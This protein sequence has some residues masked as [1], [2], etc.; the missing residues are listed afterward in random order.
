MEQGHRRRLSRRF[1]LA[2]AQALAGALLLVASLAGAAFAREEIRSFDSIVTLAPDGAV[3]VVETIVVNAEGSEIHHG[4]FRD[5]D[6]RL[7]GPDGLARSSTLTVIAVSRD[8]AAEPYRVE[9]PGNGIERIRI[10]SASVLLE[11]RAY[12]YSIHYAMSGIGRSFPDHDELLWDVTGSYWSFPILRATATVILPP[13]ALVS[14]TH[15]RAGGA[16]TMEQAVEVLA[17]TAGRIVFGTTRT[18][19]P[20]EGLSIGVTF[21]KGTL[22]LAGSAQRSKSTGS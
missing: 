9:H 18:L 16:G 4:I 14:S 1:G 13:G 17:R 2:A 3:D 19:V 10:G 12:T 22:A 7:T 21:H 6:T 8:G 15:A 5:I 20:G 11:R